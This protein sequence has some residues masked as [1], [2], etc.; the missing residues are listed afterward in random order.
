MAWRRG[1]S[2]GMA[3]MRSCQ[4]TRMNPSWSASMA[5][6]DAASFVFHR[7]ETI[8]IATM[9]ATSQLRQKRPIL[10]RIRR[11]SIGRV[12]VCL[13]ERFVMPPVESAQETR[14]VTALRR[15]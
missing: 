11:F 15:R 13:A 8:S 9:A 7:T 5:R 2:Q 6:N 3:S 1:Q 12:S 4:K 14:G 10:V